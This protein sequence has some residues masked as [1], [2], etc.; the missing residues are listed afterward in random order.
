[1]AAS[2]SPLGQLR[3]RVRQQEVV[4]ELGQRALESSDVDRLL[5]DAVG[6][7]RET[8]AA[9]YCSVFELR[10][11]G[12]TV[13]LRQSDGRKGPVESP[14]AID[15]D[16]PTGRT[17]VTD[18]PL[19]VED[20]AR[21]DFDLSSANELADGAVASS[22]TVTI[23]SAEDPWGVLGVYTT[24]YR[25]FRDYD[26]NFVTSVANVV[27]SAIEN[28]RT[29][30][31]RRREE[32]LTER[33]VET[34]PVGIVVT[35]ETGA[36]RLAN[37]RAAAITGRDRDELTAMTHEDIRR[38]REW[39]FVDSAG[40]PLADDDL[41]VHR[42]LETNEPVF[43]AEFGIRTPDGDRVWIRENAVPM[44]VDGERTGVVSAFEDVTEQRRYQRESRRIYRAL[45]TASEGI[46]LLDDEGRFTYV[47]RAYADI[48]G[49][50]PEDLLGEHW[51]LLYPDGNIDAVHE[52]IETQL[53]ETGTW[54]GETTG[55]RS[56]GTQ[57]V[58]D[59]YLARAGDGGLVCVVRD[60]T[61]RKQLETELESTFGRISDAFFGLDS[62]W[63]ITFANDRAK[64]MLG[65]DD[66]LVG[67]TLWNA[68]PIP[69]GSHF[70]RS[71][72]ETM[73]R[74][75]ATSFEEYVAALD[76]WFEVHTYPSETG[77]SVYVQ[78]VTE[79][80][81]MEGEL[82]ETNQTLQRLYAITADP[83]LSFDEKVEEVLALGSYRLGLENGF[84]AAIDE[85]EDEDE[86]RFEIT[87]AAADGEAIHAGAT[88]PL[89][90]TY[91]RRTLEADGVF[92]FTD[93]NASV[94]AGGDFGFGADGDDGE[95]DV[96][97]DP[98][99]RPI[100]AETYDRW[101]LDCYLGGTV[102]VDGDRYGTL[103]FVDGAAREASFTPAE[104]SFVEL[105]AQWVSY[106]L[107]RQ[108]HH[109]ELERFKEYTDDVLDAIDDVFYVVDDRG[110]LQ[111]WNESIGRVTGYADDEIERMHALEFFEPDD[112]ET[113][114]N[115]IRTAFETGR[116]RVEADIVT[117]AGER[118]PYEFIASRLTDPSGEPVLAGI[119]RDISERRETQRRLEQL[120]DD[121][122]ESNE[123]LEQFAYAASH[124]LQEPLRMVS[125]YMQLLERRYADDLDDDAREFIDFAVDGADRMREMIDGLLAYSRI[126]TQGNPFQPVD[127]T[128]VLAD[129]L[130]DLEMR[131]DETDADV[132][133]GD[134]PRVYGDPGQ[135]RQLF[136]NLL[137]NAITYSG[138]ET[139]RISVFAAKE[140]TKWV[141]S[142]RDQ[143]IGIDPDDAERIFQV[144]DR[145][146]SRDEY[147]G[148]GIGL[149]LCQRIVERHG[150]TIRVDSEPG[151]GA[152][153]S[154]TLPPVPQTD[155]E[156]DNE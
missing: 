142:V 57:F 68:F 121:L 105:A 48:Y 117:N 60:I 144:F 82:R 96:D 148:T 34:S 28:D 111:R 86:D 139:P 83:D 114:A 19:V 146:H 5:R 151:D 106:E 15:P 91:C 4:A 97:A 55:V 17:L 13:G 52:E 7:V 93:A 70:E 120:V 39:E 95:P 154:V 124:D 152:T 35:D 46:S 127:A 92:G 50:E 90:E 63:T 137:D 98:T 18:E 129:V 73:E 66:G 29:K 122:E 75:E 115:A 21:A 25:E 81:E 99:D 78:D 3:S 24:E 12:E 8:L 89:S 130:T 138:T 77:L 26:V 119:G 47:N 147:D 156:R 69:E 112:R 116:T 94:D 149:A 37:E 145:L 118:L 71:M 45:E 51:E 72:R 41:P 9:E 132:T 40:D 108:R 2:D 141:I 38:E 135:L 67:R 27:A 80:K 31:R 76:T 88:A 84:L 16:S 65:A 133:I 61:E 53:A 10:A 123:R 42:V 30:R 107:E 155:Q 56:D 32:A 11:D 1:M 128:D 134:L 64:T 143:G 33:I 49:Y 6:A 103:C 20:H 153:F 125:S 87:H 23:G 54:A 100:D 150:G 79:R 136:Q 113:I 131:I 110:E 62:N 59:H 109:R 22:I 44:I 58:E 74:Q 140:D 126:D 101:E 104:R 85:D 36:I 43:D 102:T 14:I